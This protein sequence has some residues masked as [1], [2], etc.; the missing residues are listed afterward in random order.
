[1]QPPPLPT[2]RR[3]DLPRTAR[4]PHG[5]GPRRRL[6]R[7]FAARAQAE[8]RQCHAYDGFG[9]MVCG[10]GPELMGGPPPCPAM[11]GP[12]A[13]PAVH[14]NSRAIIIFNG[15]ALGVNE[16]D[17]DDADDAVGDGDPVPVRWRIIKAAGCLHPSLLLPS[18]VCLS[19]THLIPPPP[20]KAD[21][22]RARA[23]E[24]SSRLP[25]SPLSPLI[26][27][28]NPSIRREEREGRPRRR[29]ER[30]RREALPTYLSKWTRSTGSRAWPPP[31]DS[32]RRSSATP[33]RPSAP[34]LPG[35]IDW[36][37][38]LFRSAAGFLI[39]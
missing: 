29:D 14:A 10:T 25:S 24:R 34:S 7:P 8:C 36:I 35:S 15:P 13:S 26:H 11:G 12:W 4:N 6:P 31:S 18:P 16:N 5:M 33:V 23:R 39:D 20:D 22:D 9:P 37:D 28:E 32:T 19:P 30:R 21:S 3:A 1:M 17:D 38:S 2:S 27:R